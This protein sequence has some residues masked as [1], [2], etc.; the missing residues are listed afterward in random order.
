MFLDEFWNVTDFIQ[1]ERILKT[2][3]EDG[4]LKKFSAIYCQAQNFN[5]KN[6]SASTNYSKI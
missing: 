2:L 6:Q 3:I 5:F 1:F 4:A